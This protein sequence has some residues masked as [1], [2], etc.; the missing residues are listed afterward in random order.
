MKIFFGQR[1]LFWA[2]LVCALVLPVVTQAKVNALPFAA[3]AADCRVSGQQ[4]QMPN[5]ACPCCQHRGAQ[6]AMSACSCL[7]A[8]LV[9]LPSVGLTTPAPPRSQNYLAFIAP[10]PEI[11]ITN[12][13]RPPQA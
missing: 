13:F 12:I 2:L 11:I 1:R 6:G 10:L 3:P 8:S 4:C 7:S 5:C 9:F